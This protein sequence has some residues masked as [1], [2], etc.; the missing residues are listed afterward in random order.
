MER[1][2]IF[3]SKEI[4]YN[5]D[6]RQRKTMGIRV[7]TDGSVIVLAPIETLES[8]IL[9]KLKR[10]APWILKQIKY[11]ETF[12]LKTPERQYVSGE[13][14]LYLGKQYRLKILESEV[15]NVKAIRGTLEVSSPIKSSNEVKKLLTTWYKHRAEIIFQKVLTEVLPLF[16]K[17]NI[18]KPI[19]Q[20]RKMEKRWGS[21]TRSGKIILNPDLIKAPKASIEYVLIH[22]LAHLVHFNHTKSF[23]NLQEQL[24]PDWK[25]W[26]DRLE[27]SLN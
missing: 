21:C 26:K 2:L 25:K 5:L 18:P 22:E 10:K 24:M 19:L 4:I 27:Y 7:H 20:L 14:H 6:Y 15:K 23:Y 1:T 12:K 11:F 3:G 16:N 8:D 9:E 17:Y 13:T